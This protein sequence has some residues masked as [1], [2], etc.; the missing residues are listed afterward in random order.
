MKTIEEIRETA[1][2]AADQIRQY[3][4]KLAQEIPIAREVMEEIEIA[5]KKGLFSINVSFELDQDANI[6]RD[7]FS[8]MGYEISIESY[9]TCEYIDSIG[10]KFR[11][12]GFKVFEDVWIFNSLVRI[13]W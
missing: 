9:P 4:I 13:K 7:L 6:I 10:C 8:K 1:N 3:T 2:K 11:S 5:S 12:D